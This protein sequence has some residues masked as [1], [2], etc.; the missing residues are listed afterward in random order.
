M[1]GTVGQRGQVVIPK[2][3]RERLGIHPGQ[4]LDFTEEE[5]RV[6][7]TKN[8]DDDPVA[9]VYG[10]LRLPASSDELIEEM[11]GPAELPSQEP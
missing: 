8:D 10:I 6:V 11:R 4:R 2:L 9:A 3:I 5:G 7:V 1:K